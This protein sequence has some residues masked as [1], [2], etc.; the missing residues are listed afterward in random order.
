VTVDAGRPDAQAPGFADTLIDW[1]RRAGRHDLPWQRTRDPYRIWVSEIMLQQTQVSTVLDYYLRFLARFPDV[2]TLAA[3]PLDEVLRHWSGL[4]YYTRARNLHACARAVAAR[5]DGAFPDDP[6][7]LE[8]LPGIGRSTAAAIAA[9][10]FGVRAPI[11]DGNVKRVLCRVFAV[12]GFPGTRAVE[13]RLWAIAARE[14]PP[15]GEGRVEAWTQ[16][17]MDLGATVCV[18]T[19]PRCEACPVAARC[20]ARA[21]DRVGALPEARPPRVVA[22]R[23]AELVLVRA[24]DAVALERRVQ[25]GLWGGL[26]SLPEFAPPQREAVSAPS[27]PPPGALGAWVAARFGAPAVGDPVVHGEIR[28]AFTHFRLHARIWRATLPAD[29][30]R[31]PVADHEWLALRDAA[32]APLPRPIK[33]LLTG[34]G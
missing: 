13:Q 6:A 28:H 10:A 22:V 18:R 29:A 33:T 14:M 32:G 31:R 1:Q 5:A 27:D 25:S 21:Q 9:F 7:A 11:L 8:A 24:G 16:G 4:G 2:A 34:L 26:W 23:R 17:L 12:D 3:A 15:A 20:A 19:R 30:A